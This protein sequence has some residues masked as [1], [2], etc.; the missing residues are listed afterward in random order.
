[1]VRPVQERYDEADDRQVLC[2]EVRRGL[3]PISLLA[4]R[5]LAIQN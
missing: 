5:K 2:H 3:A 4:A 1:M